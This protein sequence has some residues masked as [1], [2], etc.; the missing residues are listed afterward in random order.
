MLGKLDDAKF[1]C[2][3]NAFVAPTIMKHEKAHVRVV[4]ISL[5]TPFRNDNLDATIVTATL[6]KNLLYRTGPQ[7]L[8]GIHD[9]TLAV[10]AGKS[11]GLNTSQI[12]LAAAPP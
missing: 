4:R 6:E 2:A 7:N 9:C 11:A 10:T 5:F 3:R 1:R 8:F 12:R